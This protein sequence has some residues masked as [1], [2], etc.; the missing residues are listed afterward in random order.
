MKMFFCG[1]MVFGDE[2]QELVTQKVLEAFDEQI[3]RIE[4]LMEES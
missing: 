3:N 2:F 4:K 1:D